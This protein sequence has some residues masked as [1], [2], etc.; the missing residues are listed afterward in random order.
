MFEARTN[1]RQMVERQLAARGITDP[2]ILDAMRRVP[3]DAFVAKDLVEFAYE[4]TPLPIE[5]S[6]TISQ[7]FIVALMIE[8]LDLT[9]DDRVLEIGTGSGYAAAVL[10]EIAREVYTVER[11]GSLAATAR[12]RLKALG[13]TNIFVRHGDGTRGWAEHAPY[14]AIVVA[15]GGPEIPEPLMNQLAIGGTLVIPTGPAPRLQTLM[16]VRRTEEGFTHEALEQVRFVPLIGKGGWSD[17]NGSEAS[18]PQTLPEQIG[19]AAEP[20]PSIPDANLDGL[21]ER[22]GNARVVLL[23]E[24]SHG[25]AEFYEMRAEISK[26]L[27]EKKGFK[28]IAVEADWPDAA[29]VDHYIRETP[30][31]ETTSQP[32]S[33]FPTWMWANTE[34]LDL[35]EWLR[36]HNKDIDEPDQQV[37]FYGLD[38]YSMYSSIESVLQYLNDIDPESAETARQ[39]YACLTPWE[40]DPVQY[41]AAALSGRFKECEGDVTRM[42]QDLL[43]KRLEYSEK[44]GQRFFNAAQNARLVANAEQ[45]YRTM[46]YGSRASWNLRDEHMFETLQNLLDFH[47]QE[48]RAIIWAHNSHIGD[49]SAT[50]M[51]ARGEH[52][53]GQLCRERLTDSTYHIGFG[54]DHGTVAAA[55]SWDGPLEIKTVR[56]AHPDSYEWLCHQSE[57]ESFLLPLAGETCPVELRDQLLKQRLERAIGV[58]YRPETEM[59]SHYFQAVLPRQFD[60]YIWFDESRAVHPLK[61]EVPDLFPE[62]FPFGV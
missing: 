20:I 8:A 51:S 24:A 47:G 26:A 31:R 1:R 37:G 33:R 13:Y 30:F 12:K 15:A 59:Q 41:G 45:Y 21:L 5:E 39:R 44:D 14:D 28:I 11:H 10:A 48:S 34:V 46:Y 16:R 54:T 23:G 35:V 60:E 62:T 53:I 57:A 9:S 52:N 42:L 61:D 3:R 17:A 49:A 6:Q 32:F 29:R 55:S 56:P 4:D 43:E 58:I 50:E 27:I 19:D 7:P 2:R 18:A 25:T 22:I 40:Q 36:S 38:L